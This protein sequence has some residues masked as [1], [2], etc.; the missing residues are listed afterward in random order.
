MTAG[1]AVMIPLSQRICHSAR[2][3]QIS[4]IGEVCSRWETCLAELA[5]ARIR[6]IRACDDKRVVCEHL[7]EAR[8]QNIE[9]PLTGLLTE[10]ESKNFIEGLKA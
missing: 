1:S 3:T 5:E 8:K 2:D 9:V 4:C 10:E 6:Y 7:N